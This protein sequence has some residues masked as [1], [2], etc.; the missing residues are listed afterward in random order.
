MWHRQRGSQGTCPGLAGSRVRGREGWSRPGMRRATKP[1][2]DP[3]AQGE[4][5]GSLGVGDQICPSLAARC[6]GL[7]LE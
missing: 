2:P 1:L 7:D 4:L 3:G 5:R 6:R